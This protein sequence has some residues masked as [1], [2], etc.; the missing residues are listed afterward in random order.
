MELNHNPMANDQCMLIFDLNHFWLCLRFPVFSGCF[1]ASR[2]AGRAVSQP[3]T[4]AECAKASSANLV[5]GMTAPRKDMPNRAT[6]VLFTS[7]PAL[8]RV[9]HTECREVQTNSQGQGL[10]APDRVALYVLPNRPLGDVKI[11][12]NKARCPQGYRGLEEFE[13]TTSLFPAA[14]DPY[15][16]SKSFVNR[17]SGCTVFILSE[18]GKK[19][20]SV[21]WNSNPNP[22]SFSSNFQLLCVPGV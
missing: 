14:P 5:V 3:A 2:D 10:G 21:F 9:P 6:C 20:V 22:S 8:E 11:F 1:V 12:P 15:F 19:K 18:N 13:C 4:L 7:W 17:P 16:L